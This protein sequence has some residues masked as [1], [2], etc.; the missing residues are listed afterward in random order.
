MGERKGN[1]GEKSMES[2]AYIQIQYNES[3]KTLSE[4]GGRTRENGNITEKVN[5]S[6]VHCMQVCIYHNET[7]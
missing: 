1:L 4:N 3:Q 2:A 7:P 5:L 6:K